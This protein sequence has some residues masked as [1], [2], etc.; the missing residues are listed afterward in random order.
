M[1]CLHHFARKH[2]PN[3]L[4]NTRLPQLLLRSGTGRQLHVFTN[5]CDAL[6]QSGIGDIERKQR[7]ACSS[8]RACDMNTMVTPNAKGVTARYHSTAG[9]YF[10]ESGL[11]NWVSS[12]R[13][14]RV[15]LKMSANGARASHARRL[16]LLWADISRVFSL[17]KKHEGASCGPKRSSSDR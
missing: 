3:F 1:F 7:L 8:I 9:L 11:V 13:A 17:R 5:M 10:Y 16:G 4:R 2:N 14:T 6:P 15:A 12:L